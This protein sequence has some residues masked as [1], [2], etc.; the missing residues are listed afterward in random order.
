MT[1]HIRFP[2][3]PILGWVDDAACRDH[4]DPDLWTGPRHGGRPSAAED[5]RTAEAKQICSGCPVREKCLAA[6]LSV[7]RDRDYGIWGGLSERERDTIR[8]RRRR[9][10]RA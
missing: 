3:P 5:R 1:S 2:P 9:R 7:G 4:P 10:R 6:A 8:R